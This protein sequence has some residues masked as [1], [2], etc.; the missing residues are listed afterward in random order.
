MNKHNFNV[1]QIQGLSAEKFKSLI[2]QL[3]HF[4]LTVTSTGKGYSVAGHDLVGILSHDPSSNILTVELHQVPT[5]VTPGHIV[6]RLYD[7]ILHIA[8]I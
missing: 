7:Q 5:L 1:F 2:E 6:G 3:S 4:E 8:E